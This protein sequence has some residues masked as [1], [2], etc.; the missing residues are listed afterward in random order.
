M[1]LKSALNTMAA[2]AFSILDSVMTDVVYTSKG[3]EDYDVISGTVNETGNVLFNIRCALTNYKDNE[4]DY[5][6][7]QPRDRRCVIKVA[8]LPVGPKLVDKI[9]DAD[10]DWDII[11]FKKEFSESVYTFHLRR[12]V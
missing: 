11:E 9:H 5:Q 6:V 12:P 4:I 2:Q 1:S 3:P 7:I 8:D 10:G